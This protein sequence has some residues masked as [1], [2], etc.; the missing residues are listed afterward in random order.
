MIK[1]IETKYAG[2]R[3]RSRLEARWA[4][5]FDYLGIPWEYE[6]EGYMVND[7]AYLPDFWLPSWRMWLEV[8][9]VVE[10]DAK[11]LAEGL[12]DLTGDAVLLWLG[13]PAGMSS[14]Y[15]R[16]WCSDVGD[17][18]G[19]FTEVCEIVDWADVGPGLLVQYEHSQ[20]EMWD[21]R[22]SS[23]L[24]NV[25]CRRPSPYGELY[26]HDRIYSATQAAKSAR[27]EHGESP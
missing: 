11:E 5:F 19:N 24:P 10:P 15:G 17:S 2:H 12:A 27:F 4:V 14:H 6:K 13:M 21:R 23:Q 1:A 7:V 26:T 20:K 25:R 18:A 3:F 9:G 8:K 22:M 16:I